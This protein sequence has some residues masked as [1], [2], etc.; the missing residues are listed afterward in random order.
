MIAI[1]CCSLNVFFLHTH[2]Q[3][4]QLSFETIHLLFIFFFVYTCR[5]TFQE[6]K[7]ASN[8][9]DQL[10]ILSKCF[11]KVNHTCCKPVEVLYNNVDYQDCCCK[12]VFG[13]CNKWICNEP[14]MQTK[15]KSHCHETSSSI[16]KRQST[17]P[18]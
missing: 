2:T 3:L 8:Q 7:N 12:M 4:V 18:D 6:F 13:K 17:C 15:E 1:C 5:V 16:D 11:N 10:S 14:I 9:N